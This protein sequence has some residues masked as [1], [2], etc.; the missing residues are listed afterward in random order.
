MTLSKRVILRRALLVIQILFLL[1][2]LWFIYHLVMPRGFTSTTAEVLPLELSTGKFQT[3]YYPAKD[4]KGIVIVATGDGGWSN[5]FEEPLAR[6]LAASGFAVGGWDCRKFADTRK[7]NQAQL[8][9]SF[10]AAVAAVRK[11]AGMPAESPVWFTGWST[12]AEW[13]L[14]AAASTDREK[15]LVGVLAAAPGD[16][17]RYGITASD[18]LGLDPSGPDTF[19][20]VDLASG[21]KGVRVVQFAAALDVMDDVKWIESLGPETPHKV[22]TIP[23]APHDMGGAG[24]RFQSD[25]DMAVQWMLDTPLQS[26]AR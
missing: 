6:H 9:E 20:L 13:S 26:A 16:R 24:P 15:H 8:A 18:L 3:T 2:I 12:G 21:L 14:A 23:S 17:S 7:F 19:A 5:Q 22:V 11:R 1:P 10:N 25:F 4:P